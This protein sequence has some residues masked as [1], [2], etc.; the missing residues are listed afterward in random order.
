LSAAHRFDPVHGLDDMLT[1]DAL[2]HVDLQLLRPHLAMPGKDPARIGAMIADP[3][4]QNVDVE[5]QIAGRLR[6][7][8]AAIPDQL[9]RI[10]LELAAELASLNSYPRFQKTPYLG[11]HET[12]S[13]SDSMP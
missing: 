4:A 9:Y 13:S 12:G 3:L 5:I 6:H 11:A 7:R 1:F 8:H 2:V 10:E